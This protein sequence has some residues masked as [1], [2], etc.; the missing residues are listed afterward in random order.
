MRADMTLNA[1]FTGLT[2]QGNAMSSPGAS[3]STS[4]KGGVASGAT[5]RW[6]TRE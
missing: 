3:G 5:S 1:P 2:K 6:A 4:Q